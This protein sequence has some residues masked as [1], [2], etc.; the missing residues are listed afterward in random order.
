[1]QTHTHSVCASQTCQVE[2]LDSKQAYGGCQ[3]N[4]HQIFF[5]LMLS[6]PRKPRLFRFMSRSLLCAEA[7]VWMLSKR[8][9]EQQREEEER[10][11]PKDSHKFLVC[12][13]QVA[14]LLWAC[15]GEGEQLL[16]YDVCRRHMTA[17]LKEK[18][19]SWFSCHSG[20]SKHLV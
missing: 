9:R 16:C 15:G 17:R 7:K 8:E 2:L 14:L 12:K 18:R 1:M 3:L 6:K 11:F 4:M 20:Q 5:F 13:W 19:S 10:V